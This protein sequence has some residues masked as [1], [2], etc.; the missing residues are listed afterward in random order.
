MRTAPHGRGHGDLMPTRACA[1]CSPSCF[2]GH[3]P[4]QGSEEWRSAHRTGWGRRRCVPVNRHARAFCRTAAANVS[5]VILQLTGVEM[6]IWAAM[7]VAG[8]PSGIGGA[9]GT[10]KGTA[11][12]RVSSRL[13]PHGS[14]HEHTQAGILRTRDP[15]GDGASDSLPAE[16]LRP[17]ALACSTLG[18]SGLRRATHAMQHNTP[19]QHTDV[20]SA[21]ATT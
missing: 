2:L 19:T 11:Q 3:F 13:L 7:G 14:C 8:T 1:A 17:G 15:P 12:V 5:Y 18:V 20:D 10:A 9:V 21:L 4:V 16:S 6:E